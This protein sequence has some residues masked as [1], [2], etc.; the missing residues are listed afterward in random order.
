MLKAALLAPLFLTLQAGAV[1][2]ITAGEKIPKAPDFE[3]MPQRLGDWQKARENPID[4]DTIAQLRADKT[5]NY[6]Y[7]GQRGW[8]TA[9]AGHGSFNS[10]E[11]FVAWFQSQ[12]GGASQPHSPQ[13]C[14]PANGWIPTVTDRLELEP[15]LPINRYIVSLGEQRA[16]VLYWYQTPRRV[17]ASEWAAKFWVMADALRDNRTDTSL[18]RV[19]LYNQGKTDEQ[20][21]GSA[22]DF[23]RQVYPALKR[24]LP[25]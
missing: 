13:V 17:I 2:W 11:L 18:V 22:M 12:R 1:Y 4:P 25:E 15:G 24:V 8:G 23:A 19:V 21:T 7:F 9:G 6:T 10:A 14:L 5:L 3:A 20:T 16:V